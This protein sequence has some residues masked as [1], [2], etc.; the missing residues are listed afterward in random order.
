MIRHSIPPNL[1]GDDSLDSPATFTSSAPSSAMPAAVPDRDPAGCPSAPRR[2]ARRVQARAI[3]RAPGASSRS[4]CTALPVVHAAA[5]FVR[6]AAAVVGVVDLQLPLPRGRRPPRQR[7]VRRTSPPRSSASCHRRAR[8]RRRHAQR[9]KV[10]AATFQFTWLSPTPVWQFVMRQ[11]LG[12]RSFALV[13]VVPACALA[14]VAAGTPESAA[15]GPRRGRRRRDLRSRSSSPSDAS[16]AEPRSGRS[17]S[18]SSSSGC[19]DPRSRASPSSRRRGS[20]ARC[21]SG[22]STTSPT[23]SCGGIPEGGAAIVRLALVTA[24]ALGVAIAA[25]ATCASRG[26]RTDEELPIRRSDRR[27]TAG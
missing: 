23:G 3:A 4:S 2:P 11:W 5:T 14:A 20:H 1:A 15:R 24:V 13:T 18:C 27:A 6:G 21:S 25:S 7:S 16:P 9:P 22:S 19:S 10:R 12:A 8:R 26:R 17:H